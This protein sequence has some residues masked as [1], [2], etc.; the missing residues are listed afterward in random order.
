M[1]PLQ[2]PPQQRDVL[3]AL[4]GGCTLECAPECVDPEWTRVPGTY[5]PPPGPVRQSTL[6]SLLRRGLVTLAAEQRLPVSATAPARGRPVLLRARL[7][8]TAQDWL[9]AETRGVGKVATLIEA[10]RAAFAE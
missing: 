4:A 1:P 10:A 8:T 9:R 2:L 5:R 3:A 7:T 6:Q